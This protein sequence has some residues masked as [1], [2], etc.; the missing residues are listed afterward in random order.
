AYAQDESSPGFSVVEATIESTQAA[1]M[2]GEVTCTQVVQQYI[3]RA[4]AYNGTCTALLTEDGADIAESFGYVRAGE[5]ISFPTQTVPASTVFP[6]LDRYEG[7][8]LDYGRMELS[9]S[10]PEVYTQAGMRVGM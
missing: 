10:N 6:D 5:P 7:L 3:D 9:A 8:P 2:A 4:A 1:I